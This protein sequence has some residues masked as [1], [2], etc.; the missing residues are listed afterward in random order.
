MKFIDQIKE[1]L[2]KAI[3]K[4]AI[5]LQNEL[6]LRAPFDNGRLRNS[7]KVVQDGKSGLIV[8]MVDYAKFI[9]F[10]TPP[11]IIKPKSK[12][13]LRFEK[14]R[15]GRLSKKRGAKESDFVFAKKV[16]H[17]GTR[18]NPFIR[19]TFQTKFPKIIMEEVKKEIQTFK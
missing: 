3:P 19:E 13:A 8:F 5:R 16:K 2:E 4:I 15:K 11:H 12:E 18:P 1:A 7:I 9:E 6:V 10:G 17:P 14:D